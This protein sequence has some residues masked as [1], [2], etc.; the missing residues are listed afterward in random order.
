MVTLSWYKVRTEF[1]GLVICCVNDNFWPLFHVKIP[2]GVHAHIHGQLVITPAHF[3]KIMK[4][5]NT[6]QEN[7]EN[8][9]NSGKFLILEILENS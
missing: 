8:H 7:Q 2:K 9:E 6:F 5:Q 3:K 1:P 4:T